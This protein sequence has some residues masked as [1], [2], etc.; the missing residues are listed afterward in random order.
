MTKYR[1]DGENDWQ[2]MP[3]TSNLAETITGL[4]ENS[5]YEIAVAARYQRGQWGPPSNPVRV[6]TDGKCFYRTMLRRARLCHSMSSLRLSVCLSVTFRYRDHIGWNTSKIISRL[7]S[8]S[9]VLRLTQRGRSGA[10]GTPPK[11]GWNRG[12]VMSAKTF[13]ISETVQDYYTVIRSPSSAF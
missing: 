11:L 1:K 6:E 10:T 4:D 3:E 13:N 9:F 2:S 12:G 8:P 7:I 5:V